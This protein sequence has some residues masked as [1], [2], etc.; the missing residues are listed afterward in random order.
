MASVDAPDDLEDR[1]N[2]YFDENPEDPWEKAVKSIANESNE[3]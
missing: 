1:V 2:E 3:N